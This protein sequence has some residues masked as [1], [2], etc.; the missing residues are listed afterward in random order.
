MQTAQYLFVDN[1]A[2]AGEPLD[3]E[4]ERIAK[5]REAWPFDIPKPTVAVMSGNGE[6]WWWRLDKPFVING[7]EARWRDYEC[8]NRALERLFD[9]D[10]CHNCERILRLPGTVNLPTKTKVAKGRQPVAA[11]VLHVDDGTVSLANFPKAPPKDVLP[12]NVVP[13]H[14]GTATPVSQEELD[15]LPD[16][17][18]AIAVTGQRDPDNPVSDRSRV[19]YDFCCNAIRDEVPDDVIYRCLLDPGLAISGHCLDQKKPEASARKQIED[20]HRDVA[21]DADTFE[22]DDK[23]KPFANQHNIRVALRALGANLSHDTFA[24]RLLLNG[25]HLSDAAL[26]EL[27]LE[28]ERRFRFRAGKDYYYMVVENEARAN[29]FHPVR[30]YLD[31]LRWDGKPRVD[32][33]LVRYCRAE[34]TDFVRAA[35]RLWL[36]AAVRRVW[37]PGCKFDEMLV[38]ESLQGGFKSTALATLAVKEEWFSDDLPLNADTKMVIE[39]LNGRWIVEAAELKGMR[40]GEVEHLKSF[41]SRRIDR[42]RMAYGRMPVEAPRQCVIVGTTNSEQYLRDG[43]GNRRY[44]PVKVGEINM[45]ELRGDRD[46]LWAEA[47]FLE[48]EGESI[49]LD[50]AL[51]VEAHGAQEKHR[52]E[53]PFVG[54]LGNVLEERVGKIRNHDVWKIV[55]IDPAHRTQD[56]NARLGDAMR[57]LGWERTKLHFGGPSEWCYAKGDG[58]E[59]KTPLYVHFEHDGSPVVDVADDRSPF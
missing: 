13:L 7:E 1:D 12:D 34:D 47:A 55:G 16:V 19:V 3:N 31:A 54:T 11:H 10:N 14:L 44:W 24:D 52:V 23:G 36:I 53:D 18:G 29:P 25:D 59:R 26:Q 21:R 28:T 41:L 5:L 32:D 37:Q 6:Q 48:S 42:A 40:K 15:A 22:T 50:T 51:W 30:D 33:W 57:E 2:R 49:R 17:L 20:A 9:G 46:Q 56:H 35:G 27:Y 4:L 58:Q 8:Y 43:T 38:L 39:R 45:V